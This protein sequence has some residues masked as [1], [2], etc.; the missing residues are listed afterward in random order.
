[1]GHN[2]SNATCT[3]AKKCSRCGATSGSA[4]GHNYSNGKCNRCGSSDPSYVKTYEIGQ[5]WVVDGQWEFTVNS[6]TVHY[7]CND[8]SN[9]IHGYTNEQVV[10]IKYT[11]KNLGYTG[12]YQD[13]FISDLDFDVYDETGETAEGYGCTHEDAPKECIVGT[14]CTAQTSRVLFNDSSKITLMV[15][16][17]TSNGQGTAKAKF[18]LNVS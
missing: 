5:K 6:V 9:N 12:T 10:L 3:E 17:N 14:K 8:I 18:V 7:L 4:L 16:I 11:Y 15:K 13:L 1:M 2:Y